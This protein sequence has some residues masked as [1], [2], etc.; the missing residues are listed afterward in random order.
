MAFIFLNI[1][2]LV[3]PAHSERVGESALVDLLFFPTGGGKT[4]SYLGL[5]A[6]TLA[7]RRLQGIVAGH[8]GEGV[9]VIMRYTL[10][11]LTSQQF[12][13]ATALICACEVHPARKEPKRTSAGAAHHFASGSGW[14][15]HWPRTGG[16]RPSRPWRTPGWDAGPRG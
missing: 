7:I 6:F 9:A 14:A 8:G 3:D 2:S 1:P 13:R 15:P 10:R 16:G 11:L 5:T 12:Q 4:E